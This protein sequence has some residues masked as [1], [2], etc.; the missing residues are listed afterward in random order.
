MELI[1]RKDLMGLFGNPLAILGIIDAMPFTR[2]HVSEK[3]IL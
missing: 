1:Q 2:D 3:V